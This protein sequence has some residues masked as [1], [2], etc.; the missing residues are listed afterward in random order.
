[1]STQAV[2]RK[3][4]YCAHMS[5]YVEDFFSLL[6]DPFPWGMPSEC[7]TWPRPSRGESMASRQQRLRAL[8]GMEK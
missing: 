6:F 4:I 7:Y 3:V 2:E 8:K 5:C 1:M